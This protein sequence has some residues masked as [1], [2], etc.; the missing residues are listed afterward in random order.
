MDKAHTYISCRVETETWCRRGPKMVQ[1]SS[2]ILPADELFSLDIQCFFA[3]IL[4]FDTQ[5]NYE[6]KHTHTS[7]NAHLNLHLR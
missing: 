5:R 1:K 3:I 6:S 2:L 7:V 4:H